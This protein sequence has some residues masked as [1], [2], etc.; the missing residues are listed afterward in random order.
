MKENIRY[1]LGK[2]MNYRHINNSIDEITRCRKLKLH[3]KDA[4]VMLEGIV[5]TLF[6]TRQGNGGKWKVFLTT[7]TRLSF[8]QLIE[9]YR[10]RW[11]IEVFFKEAKQLLNLG[12][13]QSNDFDAQIADTT[14]S[15]IA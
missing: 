3:C 5:V 6:F 15:M 13:C 8:V 4:E 12:G 14:I 10:I 1:T 2:Q 9:I 11:S 7:D